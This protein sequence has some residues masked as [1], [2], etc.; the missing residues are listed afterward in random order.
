MQMAWGGAV[1]GPPASAVCVTGAFG[2][3]VLRVDGR[4]DALLQS[5]TAGT[6]VQVAAYGT[7][8]HRTSGTLDLRPGLG[9]R[10]PGHVCGASLLGGRVLRPRSERLPRE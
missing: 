8:T 10:V 2:P 1:L 9:L 4:Y 3:V 5:S 7:L 6:S